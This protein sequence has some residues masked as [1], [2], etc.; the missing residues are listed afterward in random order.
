MLGE[1]R[2]KRLS[3]DQSVK[4]EVVA[5]GFPIKPRNSGDICVSGQDNCQS[6]DSETTAAK[7]R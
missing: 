4:K 3:G 7:M 6:V 1:M 2:N 5:C